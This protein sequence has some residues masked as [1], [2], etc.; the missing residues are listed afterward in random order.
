MRYYNDNSLL[1]GKLASRGRNGKLTLVPLILSRGFKNL[2]YNFTI[3]KIP[4]TYSAKI[5]MQESNCS[6]IQ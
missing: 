2:L 5:R 3:Q 6:R 4:Y 1:Q